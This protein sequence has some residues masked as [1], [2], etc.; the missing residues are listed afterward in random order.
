MEFSVDDF[1][2]AFIREGLVATDPGTRG[3]ASDAQPPVTVRSRPGDTG[4]EQMDAHGSDEQI[5]WYPLT[6]K[7]DGVEVVNFASI[8]IKNM[9]LIGQKSCKS[10]R[11]LEYGTTL[12]SSCSTHQNNFIHE[13]SQ[14]NRERLSSQIDIEIWYD[15]KQGDETACKRLATNFLGVPSRTQIWEVFRRE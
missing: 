14:L 1:A 9:S 7:T 10:A 6:Q 12:S 5:S 2:T 13:I 8:R 15:S 3:D 4:R 11:Y